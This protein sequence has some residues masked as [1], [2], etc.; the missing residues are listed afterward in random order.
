MMI[1]VCDANEVTIMIEALPKEP[2]TGERQRQY[3]EAVMA[4]A[5]DSSSEK[6]DE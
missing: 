2:E 1:Y 4:A 5:A 6:E 3:A